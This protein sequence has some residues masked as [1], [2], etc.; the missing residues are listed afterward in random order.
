MASKP[1]VLVIL[2]SVDKVPKSGKQI[3]WY[4]VS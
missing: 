1:R 4:L 2:T 3:G